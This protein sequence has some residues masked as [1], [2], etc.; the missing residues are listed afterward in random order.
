MRNAG[1]TKG[2]ADVVFL[3]QIHRI[4]VPN[5]IA[6]ARA[7]LVGNE[8]MNFVIDEDTSKN[9]IGFH[10]SHASHVSSRYGSNVV[11]LAGR[12]SGG[13]ANASCV[14]RRRRPAEQRCLLPDRRSRQSRS[15]SGQAK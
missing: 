11:V 1:T 5:D 3:K 10:R 8:L 14:A 15:L 12:H 6:A 9:I 13:D 2:S 4:Q 7:A